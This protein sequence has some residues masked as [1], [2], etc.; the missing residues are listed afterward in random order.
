M[1]P[2]LLMVLDEFVKTPMAIVPHP[3]GG[4]LQFWQNPNIPSRGDEFDFQLVLT[5]EAPRILEKQ[6]GDY[7][8]SS[9]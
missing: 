1:M 4:E 5:R 8:E 7:L 6:I 3:H 9:V 2:S